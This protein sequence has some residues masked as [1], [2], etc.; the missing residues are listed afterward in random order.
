MIVVN[1][2]QLPAGSSPEFPKQPAYTLYGG[3]HRYKAETPLKMVQLARQWMKDYPWLSDTLRRRV[4]QRLARGLEDF[5]VD[6]EDGLGPR[7]SEDEDR[8]AEAAGESI[9]QAEQV[10][11][12]GIRLKPITREWAPRALR[13]L[14][15]V[16]RNWKVWPRQFRLTLPKVEHPDQVRWLIQHLEPLERDRGTLALELMVE[17]P[18]GLRNL[19]NLL[20][21]AGPRCKAV[22]FGPFD[23]LASCGISQAELHHPVNQQARSE[24]LMRVAGRG[25]E[26]A[27][28]PTP[29]LPLPPHASPR[30]QQVSENHQAVRSAWELHRD[31][32]LLS[33]R[34]GYPQSWLLH[35]AQLV[36]LYAALIAECEQQ[37]APALD[38]LAAYW[39]ARG[40]PTATAGAFDD[41]ATARLWVRAVQQAIDLEMVDPEEI[42]L[43]LP[44]HWSQ[45]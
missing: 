43:R 40:A 42:L 38:R 32:V 7:S 6:F 22:H 20:Q 21:A 18:A 44:G 23:F 16:L 14:H 3:A 15:L 25:L 24:L 36:S 17:S 28:G 11:R 9:P 27:D 39:A 13:T 45:V 4:E 10:A 33:R 30:P 29:Q 1:L 12:I 8:L 35:P 34:L 5:R 26:L 37:I 2:E 19:P 31:H 41:R